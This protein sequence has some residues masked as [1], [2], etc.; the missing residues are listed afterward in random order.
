MNLRLTLEV[1]HDI[2]KPIVDIWLFDK[3]NLYLVKITKGVLS[4]LLVHF[5]MIQ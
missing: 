4:M 5:E 2:K 3:L 1:F